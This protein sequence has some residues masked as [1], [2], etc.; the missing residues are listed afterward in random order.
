M[1]KWFYNKPDWENMKT[2]PLT[3]RLPASMVATFREI[4]LDTGESIQE[5]I[6]RLLKRAVSVQDSIQPEVKKQSPDSRNDAL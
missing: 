2:K 6:L 4:S 3:I 1:Y 5:I